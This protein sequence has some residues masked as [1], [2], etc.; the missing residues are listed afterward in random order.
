[1]KPLKQYF[2]YI[3]TVAC[4]V[5]ACATTVHADEVCF[6]EQDAVDII[7]LLDASERDLE[8]LSSCQKLVNELYIEIEIRDKKIVA[9][10]DELIKANQ[11]VIKY[12]KKYE[13]AKK[14]AWYTTAAGVIILLVQVLPAL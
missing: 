6:S 5:F 14:V 3:I 10:T 2:I 12:K 13:R 1:M 9:L 4:V 8:L 7:T 11:Q